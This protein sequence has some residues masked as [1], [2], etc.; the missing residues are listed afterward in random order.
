ML[1]AVGLDR[2]A[3]DLSMIFAIDWA[4]DRVRTVVNVLSDAFGAAIV[5]HMA[6]IPLAEPSAPQEAHELDTI[7][8]G[9]EEGR[10]G[11]GAGVGAAPRQGSR[12]RPADAAPLDLERGV[13]AAAAAAGR[14]DI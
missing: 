10:E 14:K 8:P 7:Q 4:L 2:Y 6:Q 11:L 12:E 13:E 1:Q 9:A 3:S 5:Q